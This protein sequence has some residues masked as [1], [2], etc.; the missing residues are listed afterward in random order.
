MGKQAR[1]G[2]DLLCLAISLCA[3]ARWHSLLQ[4]NGEP[5]SAGTTART[6]QSE[7]LLRQIQDRVRQRLPLAA[8]HAPSTQQGA[9]LAASIL[10]QVEIAFQHLRLA[11]Q[12]LLLGDPE[13]ARLHCRRF[14]HGLLAAAAEVQ[15]EGFN[16]EEEPL[17][18]GPARHLSSRLASQLELRQVV[19]S[20]SLPERLVLVLGMHRSGTSALGGLLCQAGFDAPRDLMEANAVN[21]RGYW[22]SRAV[23]QLN[24]D[25]L[26]QLGASWKCPQALAAGWE[27]GEEVIRW[28]QRLLHQLTLSFA[29]ASAPMIKDPRF[30]LLLP[31]L[32]PWLESGAV[33]WA[34]LLPLRHPV[35]VACSLEQAQNLARLEGLRLWL[36]HVFAAELFSR[37]HPR[38]VLGFD[39]LIHDPRRSLER[40]L[41]LL[42]DPKGNEPN[43]DASEFV[44]EELHRQR[45]EE[46]QPELRDAFVAS[47]SVRELALQV[48]DVLQ[49][50]QLTGAQMVSKLD[51]LAFQWRLL[52]EEILPGSAS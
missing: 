23:Y 2:R 50:P 48:F 29:G 19:A 38:L 4:L 24:D 21:P 31:A 32:M 45:R 5:G 25:L 7:N 27:D 44:C 41:Q 8:V 1:R 26:R 33:R 43:L 3:A 34:M 12:R 16:R 22:E 13:P 11:E 9:P 36:H 14:L 10:L 47:T 18:L 37:G 46:L 15:G 40:C 49:S 35:E 30:C 17:L 51:D 39:Q 6:T 52:P 42:G 28:R 20:G